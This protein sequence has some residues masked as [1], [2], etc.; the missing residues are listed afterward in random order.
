MRNQPGLLAPPAPLGTPF[1]SGDASEC[2]ELKGDCRKQRV[3]LTAGRGDMAA[4]AE[5]CLLWSRNGMGVQC[6]LFWPRG[7]DEPMPVPCLSLCRPRTAAS[8]WDGGG[9]SQFGAEG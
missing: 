9:K 2:K 5:D 3:S 4:R 6:D 8:V 7:S 1:R